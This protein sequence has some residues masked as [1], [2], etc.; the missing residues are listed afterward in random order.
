MV[1]CSIGRTIIT[2]TGSL[3]DIK[4][5][6]LVCDE[7][8]DYFSD[9]TFFLDLI[10]SELLEEERIELYEKQTVTF[11]LSDTCRCNVQVTFMNLL[12]TCWNFLEKDEI[13]LSVGKNIIC[14]FCRLRRTKF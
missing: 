6:S 14:G 12:S 13:Y 3:K 11:L 8:F 9:L 7:F 10:N 5:F 2:T 4:G 1:R